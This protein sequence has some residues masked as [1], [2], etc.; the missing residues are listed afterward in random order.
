MSLLVSDF[1]STSLDI[2][3]VKFCNFSR[4]ILGIPAKKVSLKNV[5][6]LNFCYKG[7]PRIIFYASSKIER[8]QTLYIDYNSGLFE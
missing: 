1:A 2:I 3:P 6:T 8:G 7:R 5:E 4:F